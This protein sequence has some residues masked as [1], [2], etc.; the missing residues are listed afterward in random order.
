[1]NFNF[2]VKKIDRTDK[3]VAIKNHPGEYYYIVSTKTV[4]YSRAK[5]S[6]NKNGPLDKMVTVQFPKEVIL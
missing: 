1:M 5:A 6:A 4:Y 3:D 2:E